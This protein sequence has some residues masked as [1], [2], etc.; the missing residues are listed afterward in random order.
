MVIHKLKQYSQAF[1]KITLC[2][3]LCVAMCVWSLSIFASTG[4]SNNN[5]K[6]EVSEVGLGSMAYP[7]MIN[8]ALP[9]VVTITTCRSYD[10]DKGSLRETEEWF[11]RLPPSLRP[12]PGKR[13]GCSSGSGVIVDILGYIVTNHHVVTSY[14]GDVTD[15]KVTLY[16]G[17]SLSAKIIGID[18]KTDLA[19]LK[20]NSKETLS[21]MFFSDSDNKRIGELVFALGNPLAVGIT[22]TQGIISAKSRTIGLLEPYGGYEDFIQT[23][24]AINPDNSGGALIDVAGC[25]VGINTAITGASNMGLGYA[26]PANSVNN[27]INQLIEFGN[28]KRAYLGV[29]MPSNIGGEL[30][31]VV[32]GVMQ[33]SPAEESDILVGD[34]ILSL[35]GQKIRSPADLRL[36]VSQMRPG[37]VVRITLK[38]QGEE[39]DMQVTLGDLSDMNK[40]SLPDPN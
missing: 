14:K 18:E 5:N 23:D 24:A 27:V 37:V 4:E 20:V 34:I 26:I 32:V 16:N 30:G 39:K 28:V 8:K 2:G 33:G 9:S 13:S 40:Q 21:P 15:I 11:K 1:K 38:R 17:R 22:V 31:A 36:Q 29:R 12:N 35:G 25:L 19:V 10:N 7:D 3:M 6:C